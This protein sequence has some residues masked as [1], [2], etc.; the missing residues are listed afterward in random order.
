MT[1]N[2]KFRYFSAVA[3]ASIV[4][5]ACAA[6]PELV[7][8]SRAVPAGIDFSGNWQLVAVPG[9]KGRPEAPADPGIRIPKQES[10][11]NPERRQRP[12]SS[13]SAINVFFET[14]EALKITQT[15]SGLFISFDRAIVEEYAFGENR[16]VAVGPIEAQRVSGW[17]NETFVVETLDAEG[18]LLAEAWRLDDEGTELVRDVALARGDKQKWF[19]RQ[20]FE[21]D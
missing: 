13:G 3:I 2:K 19:L 18:S 12:R 5:V 21:R 4:L 17:Q 10:L 20:R 16:T 15:E 6:R 9:A 11:R 1:I 8:K 7:A 14:G